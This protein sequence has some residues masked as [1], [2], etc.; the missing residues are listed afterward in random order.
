MKKLIELLKR[1]KL[2]GWKIIIIKKHRANLHYTKNYEEETYLEG[3]RKDVEVT[4]YVDYGKEIGENTFPITSDDD[5][6]MKELIKDAIYACSF[7]KKQKYELLAKKEKRKKVPL[8]DKQ[9]KYAI[10]KGNGREI[11][12]NTANQVFKEF[13]KE[14]EIKLNGMELIASIVEIEILTSKNIHINSQRTDF[15]IDA[16]ITSF[17]E[18]QE[19]EFLGVKILS[20]IKDFDS[21]SFVKRYCQYARDILIAQAPKCFEGNVLLKEDALNDFFVPFPPP[22]PLAFHSN[23]RI[24]YM[25][26]SKYKIGDYITQNPPKGDLLTIVSNPGLAYNPA[27]S[28]CDFDAIAS[29]KIMIIEKSK[30]KNFYGDLRHSQYIGIKPTGSI[31]VIEVSPGKIPQKALGK[32]DHCEVVA[33]SWFN[34]DE[35]SGNFSAEIRLGYI[36]KGNKRVPFKG[37]TFTGNIF[38]LFEE[39]YLSKE[40]EV[41]RGYKGPKAILF[42]DATVSG[43]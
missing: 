19:Q 27:S 8:V 21:R 41:V 32:K 26:M 15:Y 39:V 33:F 28:E 13:R 22:T 37:G 9:I 35:L 5:E 29:K 23:A 34:P 1:E 6:H 18:N 7:T 12:Q 42:K 14:K 24:K 40:I 31:G 16:V 4:I 20:K 36:V 10:E 11:L 3:K 30:V 2:Y 43:E 38:K 25:K 17:N